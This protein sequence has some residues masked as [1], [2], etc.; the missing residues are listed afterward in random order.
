M[1]PAYEI[2]ENDVNAS[3]ESEAG[4]QVIVSSPGTHVGDLQRQRLTSEMLTP[5]NGAHSSIATQA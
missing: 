5:S 2:K 1:E 4:N 3:H